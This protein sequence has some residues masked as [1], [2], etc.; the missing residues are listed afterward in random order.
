MP[1]IHLVDTVVT[2]V[3]IH[4]CIQ[5]TAD[6]C[7]RWG[8]I[9]HKCSAN[10]VCYVFHTTNWLAG[11]LTWGGGGGGGGGQAHVQD[12]VP[13]SYTDTDFALLAHKESEIRTSRSLRFTK[14]GFNT[15]A[16]TRSL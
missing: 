12:G 16:P 10:W 5:L 7:T 9:R 8:A 14:V 1:C 4:V 2:V 3:H 15:T 6:T 13:T 11:I